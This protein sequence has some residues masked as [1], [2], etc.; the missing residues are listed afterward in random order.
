MTKTM[1]HRILQPHKFH[2]G[3][4]HGR[5]PRRLLL[6]KILCSVNLEYTCSNKENEWHEKFFHAIEPRT[7][8]CKSDTLPQDYLPDL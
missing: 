3:E 6:R 8:G 7:T 4:F 2:S 1:L 5:Q